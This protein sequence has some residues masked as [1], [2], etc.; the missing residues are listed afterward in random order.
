MIATVQ[1]PVRD[2]KQEIEQAL[3]AGL[4]SDGTGRTGPAGFRVQSDN[5]SLVVILTSSQLM[6]ND[7]LLIFLYYCHIL[8]V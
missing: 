8:V 2:M 1:A 6:I 5:V 4:A 3:A 7:Q